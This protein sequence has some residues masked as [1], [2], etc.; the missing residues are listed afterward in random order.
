MWN[1]WN[2]VLAGMPG[3]PVRTTEHEL[4][5]VQEDLRCARDEFARSAG[6]LKGLKAQPNADPRELGQQE[7]NVA[8]SS[9][10]VIADRRLIAELEQR[11]DA[12]D[13]DRSLRHSPRPSRNATPGAVE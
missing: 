8:A 13:P 9:R 11:L 2:R 1:W 7:G 10:R 6:R 3:S 4:E 5:Q 12:L